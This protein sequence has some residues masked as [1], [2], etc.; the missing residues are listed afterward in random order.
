MQ[1]RTRTRDR[2][3]ESRLSGLDEIVGRGRG[4]PAAIAIIHGIHRERLTVASGLTVGEIRRRYADRVDIH[5]AAGAEVDGRAA[6]DATVVRAGQTLIFA[7]H[8]GEKGAFERR[9]VP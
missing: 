7:N 9:E 2:D 3:R 4:S 8:A 6:D 1:E 5:P